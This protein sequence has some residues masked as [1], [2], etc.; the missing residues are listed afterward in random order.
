MGASLSLLL[1][2][3]LALP[4]LAFPSSRLLAK[5]ME[6]D[7]AAEVTLTPLLAVTSLADSLEATDLATELFEIL[8]ELEALLF[9]LLALLLALLTL[10]KR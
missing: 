7:A 10:L 4:L 5:A 3:L 6:L 2:S 1:A 8:D 9:A